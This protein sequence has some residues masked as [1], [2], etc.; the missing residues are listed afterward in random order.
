VRTAAL[1]TAGL[2]CIDAAA[3]HWTTWAGLVTTGVSLLIL[4]ALGGGK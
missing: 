2:G 4:E 1:T 3:W